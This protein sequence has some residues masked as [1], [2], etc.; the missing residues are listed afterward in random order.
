MSPRRHA[1]GSA[2]GRDR[3]SGNA[4]YSPC[5]GRYGWGELACVAVLRGNDDRQHGGGDTAQ[6]DW[7]A[8]SRAMA[9]ALAQNYTGLPYE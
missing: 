1:T 3:R 4:G 7:A 6:L 5:G 9:T 2:Q 8:S